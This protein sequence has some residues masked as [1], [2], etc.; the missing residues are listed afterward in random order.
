[1]VSLMKECSAILENKLPTKL[2]D[3]GRFSISCAVGDVSFSRALCD[4]GTAVSLM[5]YSICKRLQV[6]ELKPTTISIQLA[7]C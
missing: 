1:M 4:L 3:P 7:N 5:S 6:G 2:E